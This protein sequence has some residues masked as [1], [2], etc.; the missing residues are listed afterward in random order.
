VPEP[1]TKEIIK[2]MCEPKTMAQAWK[3]YAAGLRECDDAELPEEFDDFAL[4]NNT[5]EMK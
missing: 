1:T 2:A 5:M 4:S 3:E